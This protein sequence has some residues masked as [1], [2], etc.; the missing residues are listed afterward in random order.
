MTLQPAK[1]ATPEA[2]EVAVAVVQLSAFAVG[3]EA[4][5]IVSDSFGT[6][7]LFT[8]LTVTWGWVG[9]TVLVVA[10][11]MEFHVD[12]VAARVKVMLAIPAVPW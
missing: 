4:C 2:F 11:P 10:V 1:V 9:N 8:S 6:T 7:L 3:P 12:C 5:E